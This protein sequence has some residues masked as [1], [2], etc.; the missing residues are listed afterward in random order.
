M[1][2][3]EQKKKFAED[4]NDTKAVVSKL[5]DADLNDLIETLENDAREAKARIL[6][7]QEELKE[8]L[9]AAKGK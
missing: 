2:D 3:D 4:F 9:E 6:A 1:T 7:G 8:R 5:S